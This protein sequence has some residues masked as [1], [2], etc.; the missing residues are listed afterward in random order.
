MDNLRLIALSASVAAI[1]LG[2]SYINYLEKRR[3][4]ELLHAERLAAIEKGIP[5]PELPVDPL[6]AFWVRPD[7]PAPLHPLPNPRFPL[8]SESSSVRSALARRLPSAW[9][10]VRRIT[11]PYRCLSRSSDSG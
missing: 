5:L 6:A 1:I 9:S 2:G 3:R 7:L 4:L 11:G 8:S 10:P